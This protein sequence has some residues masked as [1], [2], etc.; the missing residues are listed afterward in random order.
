MGISMAYSGELRVTSRCIFGG[1]RIRSS[2]RFL[3]GLR[4]V[5]RWLGDVTNSRSRRRP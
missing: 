4:G 2:I 3:G 5:N 1:D